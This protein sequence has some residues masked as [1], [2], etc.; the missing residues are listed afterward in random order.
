MKKVNNKRYE[1]GFT[2]VELMVAILVLAIGLLGLASL[3]VWGLTG[4]HNAYLRT[5]ATMLAQDITERIRAN[6]GADYLMEGASCK[7]YSGSSK[8]CISSSCSAQEMAQYDLT[9]WCSSI[10]TK[11]PG[12]DSLITQAANPSIY[13]IEINWTEQEADPKNPKTKKAVTK[14]FSTSFQL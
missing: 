6:S 11:L 1:S 10:A 4:N 12:G 13:N 9:N 8:S 14:T 5:Q 3:Q 2:M 7:K